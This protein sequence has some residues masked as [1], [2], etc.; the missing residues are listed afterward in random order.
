ME[1]E[2]QKTQT[3]QTDNSQY[4][5]AIGELKKNSVPREK[6]DKLMEENKQLLKTITEYPAN[7]NNEKVQEKPKED[8]AALRKALYGSEADLDNLDYIDKTLRLRKAL[9]DEGEPDPF[10]GRGEKLVPD[11]NDY[12]SAEKVADVLQQC[13]DYA[14]GDSEVFTNELQRRIIDI[15]LPKK[16]K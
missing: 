16:H 14:Q 13:V 7:G 4:I 3:E 15:P 1:N 9:M 10:V 2:E 6:F 12:K 11:D 5:E 8:I